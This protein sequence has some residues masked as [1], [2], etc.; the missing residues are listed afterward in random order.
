MKNNTYQ[1]IVNSFAFTH[2]GKLSGSACFNMQ[3]IGV[4]QYQ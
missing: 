3:W 4:A 2:F 1:K